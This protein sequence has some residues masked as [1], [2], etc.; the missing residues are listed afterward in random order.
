MRVFDRDFS[1]HH[2]EAAEVLVAYGGADVNAPMGD[3]RTPLSLAAQQARR[4]ADGARAPLAG[5]AKRMAEWLAGKGG[6]KG[7]YAPGGGAADGSGCD[8]GGEASGGETRGGGAGKAATAS[9]AGG[10]V[11]GG[12]GE[13]IV[14]AKSGCVVM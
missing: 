4:G 6:V 11:G 5:A 12:G 1:R 10:G 14:K 8:G 13:V 3:G 9:G 2:L 7:K